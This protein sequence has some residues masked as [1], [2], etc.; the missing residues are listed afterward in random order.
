MS[1]A[2]RRLPWNLA[3]NVSANKRRDGGAWRLLAPGPRLG[4]PGH[5]ADPSVSRGSRGAATSIRCIRPSARVSGAVCINLVTAQCL[6]G[7]DRWSLRCRPLRGLPAPAAWER[8]S[9]ERLRDARRLVSEKLGQQ[10]M[11]KRETAQRPASDCLLSCSSA[12]D[13]NVSWDSR[14]EISGRVRR[15]ST[16]A[17]S[18]IA[19]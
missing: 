9:L 15:W 7:P 12:R 18:L 8:W 16:V 11:V 6:I 2:G 19:H 17:Q 13:V 3:D 1:T 10:T 4:R 14:E 5:R